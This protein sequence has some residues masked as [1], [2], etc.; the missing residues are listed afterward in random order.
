M[1]TKVCP[2]LLRASARG[3]QVLAFEHPKAGQ[4]L[5][6]GTIEPNERPSRAALR[7]LF[8]ESGIRLRQPMQPLGM[9]NIR[10]GKPADPPLWALY[11]AT[12]TNLP[13]RW[14]HFCEDE[15]GLVF[16]FFWHPISL[17]LKP[18]HSA[19][20]D[21]LLAVRRRLAHGLPRAVPAAFSPTRPTV[22]E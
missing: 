16:S 5:V 19:F 18:V 21:T 22:S 11:G 17:P 15:G 9:A 8:E 2:I 14:N 6:K 12:V 1:I 4:Q 20:N 13:N 3:P 7:E 10:R